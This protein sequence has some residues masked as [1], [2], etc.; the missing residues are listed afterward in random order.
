MGKF[1]SSA[2]R[3]RPSY[4]QSVFAFFWPDAFF[5]TALMY[6][7]FAYV[8]FNQIGALHRELLHRRLRIWTFAFVHGL[9]LLCAFSTHLVPAAFRLVPFWMDSTQ[10]RGMEPLNVAF[11]Y[12]MIA[13]VVT[14]MSGSCWYYEAHRPRP[15]VATAHEDPNSSN[16]MASTLIVSKIADDR[17]R[18]HVERVL[19]T[20]TMPPDESLLKLW[21][22]WT[23]TT[24]LAAPMVM[25]VRPPWKLVSI[26]SP[27]SCGR[28]C[29][30]GIGI[31][32]SI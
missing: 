7:A 9:L 24:G 27:R 17:L 6:M 28:P 22:C 23:L 14:I 21:R 2:R 25:I 19:A 8:F 5:I 20:D 30:I 31:S 3:N 15:A 12:L 32:R 26:F 4:R 1:P 10:G 29:G 11:V 18:A 16:T 13:C